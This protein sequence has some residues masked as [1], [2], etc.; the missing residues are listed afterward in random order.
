MKHILT[1][2]A[3]GFSMAAPLMGQEPPAAAEAPAVASTNRYAPFNDEQQRYSYALGMLIGHQLQAQGVTVD[4]SLYD[5]GFKDAQSG[6][7]L[8]TPQQMQETLKDL[9]K[10]VAAHQQQLREQEAA[11]NKK[12]GEEFLAGNKKK[13]G[14]KVLKDGLQ[15]K[16]LTEGKGPKP[17]SNDVVTVNYR[18]TLINGT[19]FDSTAHVGHPAQFPVG[20]IIP[21]WRE[22]LQLMNAGSVWELVVPAD[23]AYGEAGHP[24]QIPPNSTLVFNVQLVSSQAPGTPPPSQASTQPLTSDIIAVPSAAEM[25]QGKQPYTLKPEEVQKL[26][27]QAQK[28]NSTAH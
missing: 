11:K 18:G 17:G 13:P 8:L 25:K 23:L 20:Q 21:G 7:M 19:E 16:V 3:L 15:Y 1:T 27:K 24:P 28:T 26:Q 14:V 6:Q 12:E 4:M 5:R 9:Q 2:L 10:S 22:A